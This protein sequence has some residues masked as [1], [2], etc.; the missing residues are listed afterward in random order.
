M[1]ISNDNR[2]GKDSVIHSTSRYKHVEPG[3]NI[4]HVTRVNSSSNSSKTIVLGRIPPGD[5]GIWPQ[6]MTERI[7]NTSNS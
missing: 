7:R 3:N 6:P 4:S 1:D 2:V 5:K